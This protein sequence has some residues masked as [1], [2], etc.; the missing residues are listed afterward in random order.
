[1][2][3]LDSDVAQ[4]VRDS[5]S[6]SLKSSVNFSEAVCYFLTCVCVLLYIKYNVIVLF[7]LLVFGFIENKLNYFHIF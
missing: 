5:F 6:K 2:I 3:I 1:M 4:W 7:S